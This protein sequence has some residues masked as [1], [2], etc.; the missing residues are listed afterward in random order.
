M[1][2]IAHLVYI[3]HNDGL[4]SDGLQRQDDNQMMDII[5]GWW[6]AGAQCG[7]SDGDLVR[8]MVVG[9]EDAHTTPS[10]ATVCRATAAGIS[11]APKQSHEGGVSAG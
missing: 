2:H 4:P 3:T 6:M 1:H 7:M 5:I 10:T 9:E 8:N 11:A